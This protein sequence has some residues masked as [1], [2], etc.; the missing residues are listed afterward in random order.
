MEFDF[1]HNVGKLEMKN[2]GSHLTNAVS[3]TQFW[4]PTIKELTSA[5][6]LHSSPKLNS[7]KLYSRGIRNDLLGL[8]NGVLEN[9]CL[10]NGE[11]PDKNNNCHNDFADILG[12]KFAS[13]FR[14]LRAEQRSFVQRIVEKVMHY[15]R[16]EKL[17]E[18]S[19]LQFEIDLNN[20]H[21]E[22]TEQL[23]T[24]SNLESNAGSG[25]EMV[26]KCE[27]FLLENG[28]IEDDASTIPEDTIKS[29]ETEDQYSSED[30][31]ESISIL[32]QGC[33]VGETEKLLQPLPPPSS[34]VSRKHACQFCDKSF[35]QRWSLT[36]HI[37][38]FHKGIRK[39]VCNV[40]DKSFNQK[41]HLLSHQATHQKTRKHVCPVCGKSF[42][43]ERYLDRH[44]DI[45]KEVRV[46]HTCNVC[47][48]SFSFKSGLSKHRLAAHAQVK[49]YI[50]N[51]CCKV[52]THQDSLSRHMARHKETRTHECVVCG[53]YFS[54]EAHLNKHYTAV[55]GGIGSH[56]Q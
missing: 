26:I 17:T 28:E 14:L 12:K 25:E 49:T 51:V 34:A 13:D 37:D 29:D 50:C 5:N 35:N 38:T 1:T 30:T 54:K 41:I 33:S 32:D 31:D 48:K 15:A 4:L 46:R 9:I 3:S 16:L 56:H 42:L 44:M 22:E 27:P 53:K 11:A 52:F 7:M 40:C 2:A 18:N 39:H 36:S 55:H 43:V 45:H 6:E 19:A 21:I 20:N 47:H 10:K 24:T 23:V 8:A